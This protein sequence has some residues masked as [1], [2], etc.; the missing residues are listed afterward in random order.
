MPK[1]LAVTTIMVVSGLWLTL[2]VSAIDTT[3]SQKILPLNC[4][5]TTINAGTGTLYYLT[6]T[7]CGIVVSTSLAPNVSSSTPL[8]PVYRANPTSSGVLLTV[9]AAGEPPGSQFSPP[10]KSLATLQLPPAPKPVKFFNIKL[11]I[12]GVIGLAAAVALLV[13]II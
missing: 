13:F 11:V 4:I 5:F 6:P 1:F 2:P 3:F 10:W 9:P 8:S 7:Q 12:T